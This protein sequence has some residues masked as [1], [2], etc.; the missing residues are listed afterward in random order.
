MD[1]ITGLHSCENGCN[2]IFTCIDYLTKYMVYRLDLRERFQGVDN[3]FHVSQ[4]KRRIP[5]GSSTSP[6]ELIQ[7]EGEEH[8]KVEALL[9]YSSR[10]HSRYYIVRWLGYGP[11]HG[12]WI[13]EEELADG[14]K[15]LPK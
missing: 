3:V 12:K 7:V 5:G 1:F 10:G 4:L 6:P 2:A 11:E 15:A 13:H 8:S 14:V 9:Q